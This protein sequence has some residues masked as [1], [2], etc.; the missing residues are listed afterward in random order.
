MILHSAIERY[1]FSG[2]R[3]ALSSNHNIAVTLFETKHNYKNFSFSK[4]P[5][6][7]LC[8]QIKMAT[9]YEVVSWPKR[10]PKQIKNKTKREKQI[11]NKAE[12]ETI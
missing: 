8:V 11:K 7:F 12:K 6:E 2:H 5:V 9:L 4:V 3:K 10:I 1:P